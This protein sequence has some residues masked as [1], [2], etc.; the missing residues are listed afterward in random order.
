MKPKHVKDFN[1]DEINKLNGTIIDTIEANDKNWLNEHT[2]LSQDERNEMSKREYKELLLY[3][4]HEIK[5]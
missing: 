4:I 5:G 2:G 3:I 1:I